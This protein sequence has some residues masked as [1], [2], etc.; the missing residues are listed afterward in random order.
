MATE[1]L[2]R[3]AMAEMMIRSTVRRLIRHGSHIKELDDD[4][5]VGALQRMQRVAVEAAGIVAAITELEELRCTAPE[6]HQ[7]VVGGG[8][9]SD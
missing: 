2:A 6:A 8:H 3:D 9:E 5:S 1:T 7:T 4:N